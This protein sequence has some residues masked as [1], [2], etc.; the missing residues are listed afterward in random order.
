MFSPVVTPNSSNGH[1]DDETKQLRIGD[2]NNS[3]HFAVDPS[4]MNIVDHLLTSDLHCPAEILLL[5]AHKTAR[6]VFKE[7]I[8]NGENVDRYIFLWL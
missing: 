4:L 5:D 7:C 8:N 1:S 6:L 2:P 3:S